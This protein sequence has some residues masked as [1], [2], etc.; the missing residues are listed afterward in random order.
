MA[1]HTPQYR[2]DLEPGQTAEG[3]FVSSFRLPKEQWDARK[4]LDFT[5]GFR[6]QPNV[7]LKADVAV[8][9]R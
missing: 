8:T 7:T 4:A 1:R 9:N 2:V 5:F 3:T 6:Y